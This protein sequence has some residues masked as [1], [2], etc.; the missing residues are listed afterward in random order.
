[1]FTADDIQS[2]FRQRP[3]V[4]MRIV[5]STGQ[6]YDIR[7]PELLMVGRRALIV[8]MESA[9]NPTQFDQVTRIAMLHVTELQDLPQTSPPIGNG[10]A[11]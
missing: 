6:N 8:G 3:F 4:P 1:M 5:T 11:Q 2:R 7:H 9:E 10:P